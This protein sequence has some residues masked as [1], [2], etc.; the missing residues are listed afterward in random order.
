MKRVSAM[1]LVASALLSGCAGT[2]TPKLAKCAGP[3]RYANPYGTVLPSLPIPGQSTA[4]KAAPEQAVGVPAS[5]ATSHA[6]TP[7]PPVDPA[8]PAKSSALVPHYPS[9]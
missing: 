8:R 2:R 6:S 9:C 4:E 3:Y 1:A 5:P 7:T